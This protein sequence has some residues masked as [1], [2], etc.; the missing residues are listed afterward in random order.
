MGDLFSALGQLPLPSAIAYC[1]I[2]M[3]GLGYWFFVLPSM[4]ELQ[5]LREEN[6][7]LRSKQDDQIENLIKAIG[8]NGEDS[9]LTKIDAL[10]T[11]VDRRQNESLQSLESNTASLKQLIVQLEESQR[12]GDGSMH[13]DI[14]RV[15]R[16]LNTLV[17]DVSSVSNKQSQLHGLVTAQR[18]SQHRQL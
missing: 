17:D 3:C 16:L 5:K 8:E 7:N 15:Q 4:E 1:V 11:L 13:D 6:S 2:V 9:I 18:N 10:Y 12:R 14:N